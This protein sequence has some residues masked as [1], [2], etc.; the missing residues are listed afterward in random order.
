MRKILFAILIT[1][2]CGQV[3][4]QKKPAPNL[5]S[6]AGDHLMIQLAYDHWLGMPDS[7]KDHKKGLS[8]GA[9]VYVMLDRPFKGNPKLSVGLGLGVSTSNV[10]FKRMEVDITANSPTLPF[11]NLDTLPH[12]KKY[13]LATTY[14]EVPLELRFMSKPADPNRSVKVALGVKIG[15]MLKAQTK[16]KE[17]RDKDGNAVNNYIEKQSNKS[18]FNTTRVSGTFRAGYG[19]FGVFTAYSF[20]S[21]FKDGV[22]AE[23]NPL[24]IGLTITG[25]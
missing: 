7:I 25:L 10:F 13:K 24:Q 6:R 14:L 15:T 3:Q 23:I 12:F 21:L 22:A 1:A 11:V 19:I 20:T 5:G 4:A 16:G 18:Y 8:R 9:N 2:M 17:L